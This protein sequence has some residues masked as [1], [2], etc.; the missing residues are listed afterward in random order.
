MSFC[1][2]RRDS[3]L[4]SAAGAGIKRPSSWP[5]PQNEIIEVINSAQTRE[6]FC[7]QIAYVVMPKATSSCLIVLE[8]GSVSA[9][10]KVG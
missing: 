9:R 10:E 2:T 6:Q 7:V 5:Q 8:R 4:R 1:T 3:R